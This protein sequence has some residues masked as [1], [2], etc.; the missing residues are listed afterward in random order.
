VAPAQRAMA[1]AILECL[2]D[3]RPLPPGV[4]LVAQGR[5]IDRGLGLHAVDAAGTVTGPGGEPVPSL[6]VWRGAVPPPERLVRDGVAVL[7]TPTWGQDVAGASRWLRSY[8]GG[9]A[10]LLCHPI[11][12]AG[13]RQGLDALTYGLAR[14]LR[15]A[16]TPAMLLDVGTA[17]ARHDL[18]ALL[19]GLRAWC[20]EARV[21]L[22]EPGELVRRLTDA[23]LDPGQGARWA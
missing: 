23:E 13:A 1:A 9:R 15:S 6:R 4:L 5:G 16:P 14:A 8:E 20:D 7:L 18:P 12:H 3:R 11:Q 17:G 21:R 10:G 19:A 22:L 2:P